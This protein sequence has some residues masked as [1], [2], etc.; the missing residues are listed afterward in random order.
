MSQDL[1]RSGFERLQEEMSRPP[2]HSFLRPRAEAIDEALGKVSIVLP[3]RPDFRRLPGESGYHGGVIASLI[4]I[5]G[6]AAVAIKVGHIAPTIDLRVDYLRPA[7]DGDLRA[8]ARVVKA[9]RTLALA[10]VEVT[11]ANGRLVA[12]GRGTFSTSVAP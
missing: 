11:D 12:V 7:P 6:H 2:F 3:F 5:A 4:D 9:G 10:D 8:D 1:L